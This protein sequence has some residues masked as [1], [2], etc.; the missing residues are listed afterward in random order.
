MDQTKNVPTDHV[1]A[2]NRADEKP[3]ELSS[4]MDFK[5]DVL[6]LFILFFVKMDLLIVKTQN[7]RRLRTL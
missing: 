5:D 2:I 4:N 1:K 7:D 6:L 3:P